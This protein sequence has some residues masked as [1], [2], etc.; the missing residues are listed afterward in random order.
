MKA[1]IYSKKTSKT[2]AT[3]INV[4]EVKVISKKH[5][6][7]IITDSD[8]KIEFDTRDVKTSI[9]QNEK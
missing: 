6:V 5:I 7:R 8:E 9:Y 4:K 2:I 3:V 1:F